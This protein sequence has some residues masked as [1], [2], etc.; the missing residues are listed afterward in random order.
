MRW[1]L[2]M[3]PCITRTRHDDAAIGVEPRIE[4]ERLQRRIGIAGGGRQAVHDGFEHFVHALSGFGAHW[5]RIGGVQPH[6]L[7]NGFLGADD[8]GRGQVNFV[9]DGNDFE[10]VV[11]GEVSI[12]QRLGFHALACVDHKERAFAGGKRAGDF[13]AEVDVTGGVDQVELIGIAVVRLVHHAHGVG[14]DGD[15]A[16]ALEIHGIEDLS[17]HFAACHGAGEL[18]QAVA[19]RRLAMVDVGND[20]EIAKEAYIH[21]GYWPALVSRVCSHYWC[22]WRISLI[23]PGR[24]TQWLGS[25]LERKGTVLCNGGNGAI[26]RGRRSGPPSHSLSSAKGLVLRTRRLKR[27]RI[28]VL[29][30]P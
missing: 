19:Q 29:I 1:P 17:L 12:G 5:N 25:V 6:S 8:V 21:E 30:C 18:K 11:D 28:A 24:T 2:R 9:D 13:V 20:G 14:L 23:C 3:V 4:D 7:L 15:A 22:G 16:F 10:T 27:D 26:V